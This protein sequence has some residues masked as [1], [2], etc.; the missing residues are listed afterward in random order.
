MLL[1]LVLQIKEFHIFF[2]P[3]FLLTHVLY[4]LALLLELGGG[5]LYCRGSAG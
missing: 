2:K 3:P 1:S 5:Q 4:M